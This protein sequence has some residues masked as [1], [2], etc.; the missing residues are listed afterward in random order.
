MKEGHVDLTKD[1]ELIPKA[2]RDAKEPLPFAFYRLAIA[3]F[4]TPG[5]YPALRRM[6]MDFAS[7]ENRKKFN[8]FD[9]MSDRKDFSVEKTYSYIEQYELASAGACDI[10]C[11]LLHARPVRRRVC[12]DVEL[13]EALTVCS[14]STRVYFGVVIAPNAK[15]DQFATPDT[16]F[17][18]METMGSMSP[19]SLVLNDNPR[20]WRAH[21]QALEEAGRSREG[22]A[23]RFEIHGIK[24][25]EQFT[26]RVDPI[27]QGFIQAVRFFALG[28]KANRAT[29]EHFKQLKQVSNANS[30]LGGDVCDHCGTFS[31]RTELKRCAKCRV[32]RNCDQKCQKKAWLNGHK[33]VCEE[34]SSQIA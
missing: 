23:F 14:M 11:R 1:C 32:A 25:L 17:F 2:A 3:I 6:I 18:L 27:V 12:D 30:D 15:I 4:T 8:A 29:M 22:A 31:S 13:L 24:L 21:C 20:P 19:L 26:T 9:P 16:I 33:K 10:L 34:F 5:V 7:P 28:R